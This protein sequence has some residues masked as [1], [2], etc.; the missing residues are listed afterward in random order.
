[1]NNAM[2][3]MVALAASRG[4]TVQFVVME[5][6]P[7]MNILK[8]EISKWEEEFV[9]KRED[10]VRESLPFWSGVGNRRLRHEWDR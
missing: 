9:P 4:I 7:E 10:L 5:R 8:A 2:L 6:Q 1:M 3:A